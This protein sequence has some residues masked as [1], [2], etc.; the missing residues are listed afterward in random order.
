MFSRD[1][2]LGSRRPGFVFSIFL[3]LVALAPS[4]VYPYRDWTEIT[5][6]YVPTVESVSAHVL[7]H[8]TGDV[9]FSHNADEVIAPASMTKLVTMHILLEEVRAGRLAFDELINIPPQAYSQ[10]APPRSSLMFL[11]PRQQATVHD[12]LL[13]LAVTSGNDAAVAAALL[14]EPSVELFVE[15]M[16]REM[17]ELGLEN[18]RFVEPSGYS[19]FNRTTAREFAAFARYYVERHPE[20]T[21]EF[22]NV[23]SFSYPRP[24]NLIAGNHEHAIFQNNTNRLLWLMPE[25]DGLKTGTITSSGF[26]LA[27]TAARNG[28]R[29]VAVVMSVRAQRNA[30]ELRALIARDLLEYG[31]SGFI[32]VEPATPDLAPV[33]VAGGAEIHVNP[34]ID[35]WRNGEGLLV[36]SAYASDISVHVEV[37]DSVRAPVPERAILGHVVITSG[38]TELYRFIVRPEHD[39]PDG[40]WWRRLWDA[41]AIR[42]AAVFSGEEIPPRATDLVA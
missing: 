28:R 35:G 10:N 5:L 6:P 26:N 12:L 42:I 39:V 18:T 38:E 13:G 33:R 20:T 16:N 1:Q 40:P 41:I 24:E 23:R 14:I 36:P 17:D 27:A 15:R 2:I 9:L 30:N 8:E 4:P 29:V 22:H 3:L 11:G 7:D 37:V 21:R 34:S 25:A 32:Q 19:P 31:L